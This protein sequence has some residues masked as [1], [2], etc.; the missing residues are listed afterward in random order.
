M[1]TTF[2]FRVLLPVAAAVISIPQ[3][4]HAGDKLPSI[5][6][7]MDLVLVPVTVTDQRGAAVTGLDRR[8]FTLLQDNVPQN[9]LAFSQQDIPCSV[10]LIADTSGSMY[11]QLG[12]LRSTVRAF[13]KTA[14]PRDGAS[15]MSVSDRPE[16][17][18]D[19][20]SDPIAPSSSIQSLRPSGSTALVDTLYLA[21]GRMRSAHNPRR[22]LVV[23]SNGM[24]NHSRYSKSEL[25]RVAVEADVQIY[26]IAIGVPPGYKKSV[27]VQEEHNGLILLE[28][29][30]ER[31]GGL[32]FVVE[33]PSH[34]GPVAAKIGQALR[35]QYVI[36]YRPGES[37]GSGKWHKIRVKLDVP[38]TNVYA[39]NGY[40][41][42]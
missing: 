39:R 19:F 13:L 20:T 34:V 10:G 23:V 24:D 35:T 21:L 1:K 4:T 5:R 14:E 3:N 38:K 28:D 37:E 42:R 40:Y 7:H 2:L 16:I 30:A 25:M 41:S 22:A 36:G 26:T 6:T 15:L 8:H 11:H 9:I 33:S 31:T 17:H 18:S 27:Q 32:H 12:A 29:L